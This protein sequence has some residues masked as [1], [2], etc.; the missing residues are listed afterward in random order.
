MRI[1]INEKGSEA[2]YREVVSVASQYRFILKDHRRKIRDYF[3]HYKGM[4]V[5]GTVFLIIVV[6]MMIFWGVE[7]MEIVAA[8]LLAI[9]VAFSAVFLSSLNKAKNAMMSDERPS[10]VVLDDAGV[11]LS[12]GSQVV[13]LGWDNIAVVREGAESLSFISADQTGLVISVDKRYADGIT[14]WL[15]DNKPQVEIV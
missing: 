3:R 11:E 13:R 4:I 9:G 5:L 14:A 2:F 6:L 8:V 7:T 15:Y 10:V 1:E 12:K